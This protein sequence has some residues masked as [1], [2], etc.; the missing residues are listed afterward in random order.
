[1]AVRLPKQLIHLGEEE[2]RSIDG[3]LAQ[4]CQQLR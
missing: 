1:M 2:L 3:Y 4:N